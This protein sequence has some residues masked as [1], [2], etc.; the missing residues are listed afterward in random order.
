ML[1]RMS[2]VRRILDLDPETSSRI[3]TLAAAKGQDAATII[4]DAVELLGSVVD[5]DEPDIDED[6][7]RLREFEATGE[8][9]PFEEVKRWVESWVSAN[10][11]SRPTP[12][13]TLSASAA[14]LS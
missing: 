5:V 14:F 9:V 7:R 2:T 10:E 8:A 11:L 13:P 6:V 1:A 3:D 12:F 4:A